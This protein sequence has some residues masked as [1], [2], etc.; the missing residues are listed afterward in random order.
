VMSLILAIKSST[1]YSMTFMSKNRISML[2]SMPVP[3][4]PFPTPPISAALQRAGQIGVSIS[5]SVSVSVSMSARV[6]RQSLRTSCEGVD[7]DA[8]E[9]EQ[10]HQP[11]PR[12]ED[13]ELA[14]AAQP[15]HSLSISPTSLGRMVRTTYLHLG[16]IT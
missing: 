4:W 9:D 12:A 1:L 6:S 10:E 16:S 14:A 13:P 11:E 7:I 5:V 8:H 3:T 15:G 2:S